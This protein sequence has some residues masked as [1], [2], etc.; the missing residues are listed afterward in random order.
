M[1]RNV[2]CPAC[3]QILTARPLAIWKALD[4]RQKQFEQGA[5]NEAALE[6]PRSFA[7]RTEF[8]EKWLFHPPPEN[9]PRGVELAHDPLYEP[10][11][12]RDD[13]TLLPTVDIRVALD[14]LRSQWNVGSIFRTADGAGWAGVSLCGITPIPP[15]KG[16]VKTALGA[17]KHIPW[18]YDASVVRELTACRDQ[19]RALV[20]LE[21]TADAV[22]VEEFQPP[23]RMVLV[24][25]NEVVGVSAEALALC[26]QRVAIPMAG[27]KAS[28]NVAVAFGVAAFA[29]A[30]QWRV[31]WGGGR[32]Q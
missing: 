16:L 7:A 31:A 26:S 6:E 3:G 18:S 22:N 2:R 27:R 32:I 23:Q 29:L 25:G 8:R 30:R 14:D 5:F 24:V 4:E 9:D 20:A 28:L 11:A 15:A 1:G 13:G 21:Q 17:E 19:G 10:G 12:D